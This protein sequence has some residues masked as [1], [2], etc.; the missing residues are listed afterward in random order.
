MSK[1]FEY[2]YKIEL[3]SMEYSIIFFLIGA[4]SLISVFIGSLG[5]SGFDWAL[6]AAIEDGPVENLSA[7]CYVLSALACIYA[8][9]AKQSLLNNKLALLWIPIC[10]VFLGEEISWGQRIFDFSVPAVEQH[11]V[12]EEFNFHNLAIFQGGGLTKAS[13]LKSMLRAVMDIQFLF[14]GG[15]VFYF[16]VAPQL[17]RINLFRA[18]ATVFGYKSP[19][20]RLQIVTLALLLLSYLLVA[21]TADESY[22]DRIVEVRELVISAVI[23]AYLA[24][25]ALLSKTELPPKFGH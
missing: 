2:P 24:G 8:L 1:M 20:P 25:F 9:T 12:Q 15:F 6:V 22:K 3:I 7:I 19:S 16:L 17:I 11:N 18:V 14:Q 5:I 23:L 21:Y 10:I 13:D 4:T